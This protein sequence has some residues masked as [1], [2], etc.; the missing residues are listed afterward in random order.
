MS[1]ENITEKLK[2]S[3]FGFSVGDRVTCEYI[4]RI[5]SGRRVKAVVKGVIEYITKFLFTIITDKGYRY[6]VS[7]TEIY[8]KQ[9]I[10]RRASKC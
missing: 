1:D 4:K 7:K 8:C 5:D 10:I 6:T 3:D 9:V 2:E